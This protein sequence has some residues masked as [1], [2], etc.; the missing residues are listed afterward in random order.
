MPF[1]LET[2]IGTF[3]SPDRAT[4]EHQMQAA[5]QFASTIVLLGKGRARAAKDASRKANAIL[6]ALNELD[7]VNGLSD[8]A[9]LAAL[10]A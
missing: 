4:L 7:G 1:T 2:S 9:L 5:F 8:D 6:A 10:V 3:T